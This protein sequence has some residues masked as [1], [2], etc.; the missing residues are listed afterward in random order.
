MRVMLDDLRPWRHELGSCL[1]SCVGTVLARSGLDPLAV[2]GARWEFY[3]PRGDVRREEYYQ[4]C[5]PGTSL[6][7]SLAP[8]HGLRSQWHSPANGDEGW[9]EVRMHVLDGKPAVV[10]VDNYWLPFRPAYQDVHSNHLVLVY[11]FDDEAQLVWVNDVVPPAFDGPLARHHLEAARDS[12]NPLVHERDMFFTANPIDNRWLSIDIDTTATPTLRES[13]QHNLH[14]FHEPAADGVYTGVAGLA[15]FFEDMAD[16]LGAGDEITEETFSV[17]GAVLASTALHAA[18]LRCAALDKGIRVLAE[19]A[20]AVDR[21]AHHWTAVRILVN[22]IGPD[23][24][25]RLRRRGRNL[26]ADQLRA[27]ADLERALP[28]M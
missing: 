9:H 8:Y 24:A 23:E 1:H 19:A 11:G 12:S 25:S 20:S 16:R 15:E 6:A 2:L 7:E 17:S 14:G 21:V 4:P 3:Y 5:R 13:V 26:V 22:V 18:V 10:A 27:L 28:E